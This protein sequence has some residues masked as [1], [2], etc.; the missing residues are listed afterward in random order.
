MIGIMIMMGLNGIIIP[1]HNLNHNKTF[2]TKGL[3]DGLNVYLRS[4]E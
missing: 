2:Q 1:N 4:T 3:I